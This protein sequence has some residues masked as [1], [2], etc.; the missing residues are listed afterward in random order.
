V[1]NGMRAD[2]WFGTSHGDPASPPNMPTR[3]LNVEYRLALL[4]RE[5]EETYKKCLPFGMVSGNGSLRR[6]GPTSG[7]R[8]GRHIDS[9]EWVAEW[10][11]GER[12]W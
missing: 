5:E 8:T 1:I 10:V 2:L 3:D 9:E 6:P 12:Y 4:S 11:E 7:V